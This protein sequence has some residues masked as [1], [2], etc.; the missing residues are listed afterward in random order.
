[1]VVIIYFVIILSIT[2]SVAKIRILFVNHKLMMN[3]LRNSLP[4]G[5]TTE[6]KTQGQPCGLPLHNVYYL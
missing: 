2:K 3:I 1:M 6:K 4:S 5:L